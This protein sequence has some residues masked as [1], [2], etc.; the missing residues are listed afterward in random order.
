MPV[1]RDKPDLWETDI[2]KSVDMYNDWFV[3]F[4]PKAF[5]DSRAGATKEVEAALTRTS[6]LTNLNVEKPR[7]D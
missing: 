7:V 4:A 3:K 5:R 6:N 1:N 2:A